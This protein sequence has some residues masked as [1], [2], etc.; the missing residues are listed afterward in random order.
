MLHL[1]IVCVFESRAGQDAS[2]AEDVPEELEG[3]GEGFDS[4]LSAGTVDLHHDDRHTL[5]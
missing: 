3:V 1:D 4:I 2:K 5:T